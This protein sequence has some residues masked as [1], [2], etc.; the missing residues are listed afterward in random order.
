MHLA[1]SSTI[2]ASV[3]VSLRCSVVLYRFTSL[4]RC[5]LSFCYAIVFVGTKDLKKD[6]L[7][8]PPSPSPSPAKMELSPDSSTTSLLSRFVFTVWCRLGALQRQDPSRLERL[9]FS[10][11]C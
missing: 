1:K 4:Q 6:L 2:E 3:P 8:E 5:C 11:P 9:V 7:A 10:R